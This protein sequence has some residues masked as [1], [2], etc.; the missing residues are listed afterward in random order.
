MIR[1]GELR[2]PFGDLRLS[3]LQRVGS[4]CSAVVWLRGQ[5]GGCLKRGEW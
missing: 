3:T 4:V 1:V 5:V 2:D